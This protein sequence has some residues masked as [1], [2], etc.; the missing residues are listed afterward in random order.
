[1]YVEVFIYYFYL[2]NH[3]DL[4]WIKK[5]VTCNLNSR[6]FCSL[7][8]NCRYSK[9]E[10]AD[11]LELTVKFLADVPKTPTNGARSFPFSFGLKKNLIWYCQY[12]N[13]KKTKVYVS[14]FC[15]QILKS[16]TEKAMRHA[17]SGSPRSFRARAL[18][19][20]PAHACTTS[21]SSRCARALRLAAH[22]V[23]ASPARLHRASTSFS[24]RKKGSTLL[25]EKR[26]RTL[27]HRDPRVRHRPPLSPCGDRG[28]C[29]RAVFMLL[30]K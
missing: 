8:Q 7:F 20:K 29:G 6:F 28:S 3:T 21:S 22:A 18:T 13:H 9:L 12:L 30:V 16:V 26:A 10:K 5:R 1:M 23:L 24:A 11:I 4:F 25:G 14:L 27:L 19:T 17:C 2:Q 15:P